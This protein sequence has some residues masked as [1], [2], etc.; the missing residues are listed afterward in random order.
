MPYQVHELVLSINDTAQL[1]QDR[2]TTAQEPV[3]G[4]PKHR[5]T[6]GLEWCA[7]VRIAVCDS[8]R[9]LCSPKS[10]REKRAELRWKSP[11]G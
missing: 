2:Q 9:P 6:I 11:W 7:C 5:T 1:T 10:S 4:Q 3:T 8:S